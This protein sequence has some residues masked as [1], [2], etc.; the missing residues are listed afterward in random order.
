MAFSTTHTV[1]HPSITAT[2]VQ[3]CM[4]IKYVHNAVVGTQLIHL[5]V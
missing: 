2:I 4:M 5:A 3:P 1:N